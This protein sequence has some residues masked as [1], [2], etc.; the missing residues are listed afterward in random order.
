MRCAPAT[1]TPTAA[2][3][4][5]IPI[6]EPPTISGAAC[7]SG[8]FRLDDEFSSALLMTPAPGEF[9][10]YQTDETGAGLPRTPAVPPI[11]P[12]SDARA[13]AR[14]PSGVFGWPGGAG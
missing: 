11:P 12:E 3:A 5:P 7:T 10:K 13:L 1:A 6:S 4:A 14:C 9:V 2:I 8:Q